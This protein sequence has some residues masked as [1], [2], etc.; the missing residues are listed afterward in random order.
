MTKPLLTI[1]I[2]TYNREVWL[3]NSLSIIEEELFGL[4]EKIEL[5][6]SNNASTDSTKDVIEKH[7]N[8][9]SFKVINNEKNIGAIRNIN[10]LINRA[11]ADLVWV[12]GDDDFLPKGFL[13]N[14]ISLIE[15]KPNICFYYVP[16]Q[17]WYP[18]KIYVL[19]EEIDYKAHLEKDFLEQEF[20]FLEYN[21]LREIASMDRGYF[22]AISSIIMSKED[23]LRAFRIGVQSGE[24]FTS[25]ET[26]FPH[27]HYIA[28]NI[29]HKRC[30]EINAPS[31]ICSYAVS[32]KSH[33]EI[34]WLKWF[35]E[36]VVLMQKNGVNKKETM[37]SRRLIINRNREMIPK[38]LRKDINNYQYFSWFAYLIRNVCI[39]EF[40]KVMAKLF[41]RYVKNRFYKWVH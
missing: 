35:P 21:S 7:K 6:V 15:N 36:L 26:T 2:P 16:I 14:L 20:K 11:T 34:T 18:S 31:L 4:N 37:K 12:L 27:S 30:I 24:E 28:K 8:N 10:I 40:W 3:D 29:L 41:F 1:A 22:N 5:I 9:I 39:L 38:L 23:Y 19:G 13:K 17:V 25:I 32:W 33:Y